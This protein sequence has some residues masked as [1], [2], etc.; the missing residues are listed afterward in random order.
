MI[1]YNGTPDPIEWQHVGIIGTIGADEVIEMPDGRGNKFGRRGLVQ[2]AFGDDKEAK[3]QESLNLWRRF[4]EDQVAAFNQHNEDQH[5]KGNRYARPNAELESHAKDLGLDLFQP[6]KLKE[7]KNIREVYE[8]QQ[9]NKTLKQSLDSLQSQVSEL[10]GAIKG[11]SQ[12]AINMANINVKNNKSPGTTDEIEKN[13]NK[14][15]RLT[16]NAMNGWVKNNWDEIQ[17]M[18]QENRFE[19]TTMYQDFYQVSFPDEKPD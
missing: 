9:E 15:K 14:Y 13:R 5:Q 4:W 8:L 3:K 10:I 6:T 19:I 7:S 12:D 1:V 16:R 2:M 17:K 11:Q 18:P